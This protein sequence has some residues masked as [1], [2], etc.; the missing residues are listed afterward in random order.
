[1]RAHMHSR[2]LTRLARACSNSAAVSIVHCARAA[3][4]PRSI[5][6]RDNSHAFIPCRERCSHSTCANASLAAQSSGDLEEKGD[7]AATV[8]QML[9]DVAKVLARGDT[10]ETFRRL[11][12]AAPQCTNTRSPGVWHVL[13][14]RERVSPAACATHLLTRAQM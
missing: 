2:A 8:Y 13:H 11:T 6:A 14:H 3:R 7:V 1:M 5:T 10:P 9:Q 4:Q 12:G